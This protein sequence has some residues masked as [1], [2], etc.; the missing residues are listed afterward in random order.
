MKGPHGSRLV[1]GYRPFELFVEAL[2]AVGGDLDSKN[3]P[4]AGV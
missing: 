1:V 2:R 4:P 3:A